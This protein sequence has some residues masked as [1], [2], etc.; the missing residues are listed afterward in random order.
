[1]ARR[2]SLNTAKAVQVGNKVSHSNIKSKKR[3]LPN[4]QV[5]SLLS[6]ILGEKVKIRA[7]ANS[8]RTVEKNAGLDNYLI[9]TPSSKLS[10]E[11]KKIKKKIMERKAQAQKA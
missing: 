1:M 10:A 3:F 2:C 7:T 8:V 5:F 6:E 11:L 4:I 9:K